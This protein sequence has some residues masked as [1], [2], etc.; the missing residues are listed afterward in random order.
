MKE[1]SPDGR[2]PTIYDYDLVESIPVSRLSGCLTGYGDVTELLR[3]ADDCMVLF[4]PGDEVS[5]AFDARQVPPLPAGW[6]RSFVLRSWGFCK[7]CSPFTEAGETV[8][9]LPF[10]AMNDYPPAKGDA[11]PQDAVHMNYRRTYNTRHVGEVEH[12]RAGRSAP[13]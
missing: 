10:R 1:F 12:G 13:R 2:Q 9:P 5:I 8:E 4:G 7:D 3:K 11:Y 6:K